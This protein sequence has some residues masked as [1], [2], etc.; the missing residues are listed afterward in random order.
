MKKRQAAEK[1]IDQAIEHAF[2]EVE[3][4]ESMLM[5]LPPDNSTDSP[6][7]IKAKENATNSMKFLVWAHWSKSNILEEAKRYDESL[8]NYD[9][10]LAYV[11]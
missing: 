2:K 9:K 4:W 5:S 11:E 8:A 3:L 6:Q 10:L 1:H 7:V